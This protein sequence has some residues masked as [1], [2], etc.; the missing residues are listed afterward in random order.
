VFIKMPV[1]PQDFALW[2]D[3]TGNPYPQTPA[4]RMALAPQVYQFTRSIG[5]RGGP[6]M[7]PVRQAVDVVGKAALAAGALA[8]AAYLGGKY[9][10]GESGGSFGK[11]GLDDEPEVENVVVPQVDPSSQV[12]RASGDITPPTT[13]QRFGQ[14]LISGQTEVDQAARGQSPQ[15]PTTVPSEAKPATQSEVITSSQ[16]FSPGNEAEQLIGQGSAQAAEAFRKSAAYTLMKKNYPGLQDIESPTDPASYETASPTQAAETQTPPILM[17]GVQPSPQMRVAKNVETVEE[18]PIEAMSTPATVDV[19]TALRNKGLSLS[20]D[21]S[22]V[23]VVGKHGNEFYLNHP[24]S[25]HPK[26][27]IR[28]TA[29]QEEQTA[30]T[31]LASAGVSPEQAK[32]YWSTK[33]NA[34]QTGFEPTQQ[35]T[36]PATAP[37]TEAVGPASGPT[38]K[39]IQELDQQLAI[40]HGARASVSQRQMMRNQILKDRYTQGTGVAVSAPTEQQNVIETVSPGPYRVAKEGRITPNQYLSDVSQKLGAL[41]SYQV[42]PESSKD[43]TNVTFYPGGEV[44]VTMPSKKYGEKEYAF[45]TSDPYRLALSDYAEEG[46]PSGMGSIAGTVAPK[47]VAHQLGLQKTVTPGGAIA[48]NQPEYSGLMDDPQIAKKLRSRSENVRGQAQYHADTKAVMQAL[49]ERAAFRNAGL[50]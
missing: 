41:A 50:S 34:L 32:D 14:P 44:G 49:Q 39:E 16:T 19:G 7:S 43:V 15:K 37:V 27:G 23:R 6:A 25:S 42:S 17:T 31:L 13:S 29:L 18:S 40:T 30:R 28:Q 2:S 10:A 4:E 11:L 21:E 47:N 45:A 20:S 3:L 46:F 1:S 33:I 26:A 22:G 36:T 8:G 35:V 24:Y 12:V 48:A 9:L 38:M 5:R